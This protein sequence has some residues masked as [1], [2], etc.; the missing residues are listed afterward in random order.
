GLTNAMIALGITLAPRFFRVARGEA[1]VLRA[2]D[3]IEAAQADGLRSHQILA[4]HV[5]P[6]ASSPILVQI[7]FAFGLVVMAEAGLGFL[8]LGARIPSPSWGTMLRQGF[9]VARQTIWPITPPVVVMVL[10]VLS[11]FIAGDALRDA[12]GRTHIE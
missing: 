6:N 9:D 5:L 11:L 1:I 4:R 7:T 10:T 3:F 12:L 2:A 8:G